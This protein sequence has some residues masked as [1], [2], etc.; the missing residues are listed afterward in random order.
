MTSRSR[1]RS[2]GSS[3]S[4]RSSPS[5]SPSRSPDRSRSRHRR[6]RLSSSRN[7]SPS[8]SSHET[9]RVAWR[10]VKL[11]E[12]NFDI[13]MNVVQLADQLNEADVSREVYERFLVR[14][15][16]CYGFWKKLADFERRNNRFESALKVWDQSV[17]AIPLSIDLWLGY[18]GYAREVYGSAG[19][20]NSINCL[21]SRAL[22]TAG[23]EF[24]SDSLWNHAITWQETRG[25]WKTVS[26]IYDK[27]LTIPTMMYKSHYE[28][29]ES[30][31]NFYEPDIFLSNDEYDEIMSKARK[32]LNLGSDECY[33][34]EE[35]PETVP[36]G[37]PTVKVE[38]ESPKLVKVRK[39]NPDVLLFFRSELLNRRRKVHE[40]TME[41]YNARVGFEGQIKRPYFHVKPLETAQ[42]KNWK[43]YLHF[44]MDLGERKRVLVLFER[45]VIACALYDEIW[46]LYSRW[47]I[48]NKDLK[49]ARSII[50]RGIVHCPKSLHLALALSALYEQEGNYKEALHILDVFDRKNAGYATIQVRRLGIQRRMEQSDSKPNYSNVISKWET[51]IHS[52]DSTRSLSSFYSIKLARFHLKIRNDRKVAEKV[53]KK[54]L[55][56]DRDNMQLHLQLID[57]AYT[58]PEFS[59]TRVLEAFD[60]ALRAKFPPNDRLRISQRKLD[61]LEDLCYDINILQEHYEI[62]H[63]LIKEIEN[64]DLHTRKRKYERNDRRDDDRISRGYDRRD[65]DR[66][67]HASHAPYAYAGQPQAQQYY[68]SNGGFYNSKMY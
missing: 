64:P 37:E 4:R 8:K 28:R 50:K 49:E 34:E 1:S 63:S 10:E 22:A 27:L 39:H 59:Q 44:E 16:F 29:F 68:M 21:Y 32:H 56:R 31:I 33:T 7:V 13:W 23:L 53:I 52:P 30:I 35:I 41:K 36:Q 5:K 9:L 15:P 48:K 42:L 67:S 12:N 20:T 18:I 25:D 38:D 60:S 66:S 11:D 65:N 26:E 55:E 54:A 2:R 62:H 14:Y 61:F 40:K 47:A 46:L 57:M 51:L 3:S 45:C 58:D 17:T 6:K 19:D 24:K 43:Q